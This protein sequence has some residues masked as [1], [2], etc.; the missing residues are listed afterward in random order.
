MPA[1]S[2]YR[3]TKSSDPDRIVSAIAR[4][5]ALQSRLRSMLKG[6]NFR[7]FLFGTFPAPGRPLFADNV[8]ATNWP[9]DLLNAYKSRNLLTES[10][11]IRRLERTVLPVP[12]MP[13]LLA[14]APHPSHRPQDGIFINEGFSFTFAVALSDSEQRR[15]VCLMSGRRRV[16]RH[17]EM[18][19]LMMALMGAVDSYSSRSR[20]TDVL[21][22]REKECLRWASEGKTSREIGQILA[23]SNHTIDGYLRA[24]MEKLDAV[25][26]TQAVATASKLGLI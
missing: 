13:L 22:P 23:L 25:T 17:E 19:M 10:P 15:Y 6:Y 7:Y 20:A 3:K 16:E 14:R 18:A 8:L 12:T 26:R 21:T 24:A 9:T 1:R 11:L 2:G 5:N 4:L